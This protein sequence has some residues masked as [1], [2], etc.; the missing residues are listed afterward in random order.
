MKTRS[1]T[2]LAAA[3][4]DAIPEP[5]FRFLDLPKEL[6]LMVYEELM[7]NK[8]NN[9]KFTAPRNL[10][11]SQVYL[12]N[13]YYPSLLQ[14]SKQVHEEYWPLCLRTSMLWI[15]YT[16]I[17]SPSEDDNAEGESSTIPFLTDWMKIYHAR[18]CAIFQ[19]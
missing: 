10:D 19:K 18:L 5:P 7:D 2:R 8:K 16:C 4:A 1:Q 9:I 17:D 3:A 12:H 11:V 14:I 13:M 15:E 6:R